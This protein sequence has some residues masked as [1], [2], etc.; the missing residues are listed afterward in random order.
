MK[1]LVSTSEAAKVLGLSLQGIHYR[2][3]N[4][5]LE[6]IKKDGKTFVYIDPK[7]T[8]IAQNTQ[9][10][11]SVNTN[12]YSMTIKS[13]D[14]QIKLLK[15]TIKFLKKQK[16]KEIKR[17]ENNQN[18]IIQV[19]QSEVDLLKSAFHEMKNIYALEHQEFDKK[20]EH[21]PAHSSEQMNFMS[22][23]EFFTFM[24][25]YN[26]NDIE[27]KNIILNQIKNNDKR[28]IYN[29]ETKGIIIYKSDFLDL[30]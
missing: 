7:S 9:N 1:K 8:N 2:I 24:K 27:I 21:K 22:L 17:L 28:F 25:Q 26:K 20:P 29:R 13:K 4:N 5:K 30:I 16:D 23:K 19:F 6:S 10:N 15:N 3:K 18:R 12:D 11:I 14:E